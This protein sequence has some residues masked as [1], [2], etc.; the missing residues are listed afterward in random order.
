MCVCAC[1]R[2]CVRAGVRAGGRAGG[3]VRIYNISKLSNYVLYLYIRVL[4]L[5]YNVFLYY[6]KRYDIK[7]LYMQIISKLLIFLYDI[8]L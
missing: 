7:V 4:T 6:I 5:H 8:V 2:A 3:R 1:V